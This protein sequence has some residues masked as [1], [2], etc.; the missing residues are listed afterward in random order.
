MHT[1]ATKASPKELLFYPL[2]LRFLVVRALALRIYP[3]FLSVSSSPT[4]N[5]TSSGSTSC[6]TSEIIVFALYV[7]LPCGTGWMLTALTWYV[8]ASCVLFPCAC[9]RAC[10]GVF[11]VFFRV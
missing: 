10:V 5:K 7:M 6:Y 9:V 3:S 8:K 4:S 2:S 11:G 1:L